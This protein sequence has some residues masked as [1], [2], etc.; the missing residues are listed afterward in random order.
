MTASIAQCSQRRHSLVGV[1][2]H[3]Q[4]PDSEQATVSRPAEQRPGSGR[5]RR[6]HSE[7]RRGQRSLVNGTLELLEP[8]AQ[9]FELSLEAGD[10]LNLGGIRFV[11]RVEFGDIASSRSKLSRI[12]AMSVPVE[13]ED[14]AEN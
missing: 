10:D 1:W 14:I 4:R 11:G 12:S 6:P 13:S 8:A 7:Q 5:W 9:R 2:R 3:S